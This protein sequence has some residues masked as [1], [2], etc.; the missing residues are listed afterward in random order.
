MLT[1]YTFTCKI[2][3]DG[4][5]TIPK[6]VRGEWNLFDGDKLLVTFKKPI[7]EVKGIVV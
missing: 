1:E 2:I 7:K 4:R 3:G 6:N 5:I